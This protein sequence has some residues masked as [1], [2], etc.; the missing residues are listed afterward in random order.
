MAADSFSPS[1][2]STFILVHGGWH[3]A[4]CWNKVVPLLK[5]KGCKVIAPDL[6][7]QGN[8][9]TPPATV[10]LNEYVKKVVEIANEQKGKVILSGHSS[11]GT[12]IAQAAEYLS[13]AKVTRL[14]FLDAFMPLDGES[15]FSL[16]DKYQNTEDGKKGSLLSQSMIFSDD[17]KT[18]T[19]NLEKVQQLLYHDCR[20]EDV[21]FAK[22]NLGGQP[23]AALAMA[24]NLTDHSYGRIPKYY[25]L[26]TDA[27]DFDKS[28][29]AL[30]VPCEK[31]YRLKSS[32]SPFF[33]MPDKLAEILDEI[34]TFSDV[35]VS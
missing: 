30:H 22:E 1:S 17:Q 12:V 29:V 10:T 14:V 31:I 11:G 32:H 8:D 2:D 33:S 28:K 27:H 9:K 23:I 16:V 19:L 20:P 3:G 21:V 18:C 4:W 35:A 15:V 25:I 24:V 13:P 7:G 34:Q 26:C 6:P 5:A